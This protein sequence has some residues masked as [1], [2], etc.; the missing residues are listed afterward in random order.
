MAEGAADSFKALGHDQIILR[1]A[2]VKGGALLRRNG[3]W[4]T[5]RDPRLEGQVELP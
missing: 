5:A 3:A 4:Q 2:P 1:A